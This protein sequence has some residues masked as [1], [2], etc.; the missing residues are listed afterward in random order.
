MTSLRSSLRVTALAGALA[1][2]FACAGLGA[3]GGPG[4][5]PAQHAC[6]PR[7]PYQ[8]GWLGGDGAYSVP[9]SSRRSVWLFGDTFV[10]RP[11]QADRVGASLVHN[12][13]GISECRGGRFA[14]DYAW[15][16]APDGTARAFLERPG[17]SAG[18]WWLFGGFVHES[19]LYLGLLEVERSAPQGSLALPFRTGATALARIENPGDEPQRWRVEVLP[20]ARGTAG[21]PMSAFALSAP[22]LYLYTWREE[23][24]GRHPRILT[25]LPLAALEATPAELPDRLE[26]FAGDGRWLA[27]FRPGEARVVM[28]DSASEM[29]IRHHPESGRWLALYGHPELSGRFPGTRPSDAVYLRSAPAPEGPWSERRLVFRIPELAPGPGADPNLGCYAAKEQPQFSRPGSLTFTYVCNLFAGL[30]QDPYEVLGRLQRSMDLYRP[31]AAAVTLPE[32][33]RGTRGGPP[34]DPTAG[35]H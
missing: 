14:I 16:R 4:A 31:V 19:R 35:R 15:G 1:G 33:A 27:G 7:F 29:S 8:E 10:G 3:P 34:L 21:F 9:L 18:W 23:A 26:T 30:G 25:R 20:L 28:D 13:I 32:P 2:G 6:W 12:S 17:G 5:P 24:D 22:H 11:D